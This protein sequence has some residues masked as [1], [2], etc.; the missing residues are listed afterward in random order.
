M[1]VKYIVNEERDK[2]CRIEA[3]EIRRQGIQNDGNLADNRIECL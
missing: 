2:P 1:I 3:K